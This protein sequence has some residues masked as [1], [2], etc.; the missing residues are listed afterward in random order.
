[1]SDF[2]VFF[3]FAAWL[4]PYDI[5]RDALWQRANHMQIVCDCTVRYTHTIASSNY[6]IVS[7]TLEAKTRYRY[8]S[9]INFGNSYAVE[10]SNWD[11]CH[12]EYGVCAK[13]CMF[14]VSLT[15][16]CFFFFFCFSVAMGTLSIS[17][18]LIRLLLMLLCAHA[19]ELQCCYLVV[20]VFFSLV[21]FYHYY[22]YCLPGS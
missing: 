3:S 17:V 11:K 7:V 8:L 14:S 9:V 5:F 12:T 18:H 20:V 2:S 6:V 4:Y 13:S 1:M 19:N 10:M 21:Y 15:L 22:Y 16:L